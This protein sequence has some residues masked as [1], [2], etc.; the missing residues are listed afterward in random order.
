MSSRYSSFFAVGHPMK[1]LYSH[2]EIS[3][4][5]HSDERT[6]RRPNGK[7]GMHWVNRLRGFH[8]SVKGGRALTKL[9]IQSSNTRHSNRGRIRMNDKP[10]QENVLSLTSDINTFRSSCEHWWGYNA[11]RMTVLLVVSIVL[12]LGATIAGTW[13]H[14][15]LA[16]TFSA[17][18]AAVITAQ[19]AFKGSATAAVE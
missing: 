5:P 17:V 11:R 2:H 15:H 10:L 14:G 3:A 4:K 18:S 8:R 9:L 12:V 7:K 1:L 13:G 6:Y 16:A 19:N